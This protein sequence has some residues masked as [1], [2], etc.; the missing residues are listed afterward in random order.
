MPLPSVL[1]AKEKERERV[2]SVDG[3]NCY[4]QHEQNQALSL[5]PHNRTYG[6]KGSE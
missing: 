3:V 1:L 4:P 2:P 5:E 6:A